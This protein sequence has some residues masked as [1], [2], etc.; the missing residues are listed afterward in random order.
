MACFPRNIP[1][2][3]PVCAMTH[4]NYCEIKAGKYYAAIAQSLGSMVYRMRDDD[5]KIEFFRF[6]EET[7]FETLDSSRE[8]WGLPTLFLPNRF[9]KGVL[10]TSD[11][12][13]NL[14][15]NETLLNNHLHGFVHKR[16]HKVEKCDVVGDSAVVVTS[17]LYDESDQM[18][19][20]F[21]VSFKITYTFTLSAEGLKHEVDIENLSDKMLPIS[22]CTHTCISAPLVDGGT[23]ENIFLSVPVVK[24]CELD[25]RCLPTEK[26]L[27]LNDWDLE[28]K[29]GTKK[30][31]LQNISNDMY[32]ACMNTLD[33]KDF[34]GAVITDSDSGIRIAN[35][36]SK[37][38][39]FWNMWND[40]GFNGYFCPEPMTAMINSP[41][42]SLPRDV[43]GYGEIAKCEK[44]SAWQK[45]FTV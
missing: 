17:Y 31:V 32:T 26:L 21:P 20:N 33:G 39:I 1:E 38:Y 23:Q 15:V 28:Y 22:L 11:A 6:K 7:T 35:E 37:E 30:A 29:N 40:R 42:L 8:V 36:V 16:A 5:K 2:G 12:V 43:T 14:P 25:E 27:E 24:K 45:F 4:D 19:Q 18:W 44:Y 3:I 10:K 13:Y 9:D 41:N 34:Y